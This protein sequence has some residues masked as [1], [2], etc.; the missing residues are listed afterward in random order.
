MKGEIFDLIG[1]LGLFLGIV[2]VLFF[3]ASLMRG[4]FDLGIIC[5]LSGLIFI[6]MGS[7]IL[8]ILDKREKEKVK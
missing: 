5:L 7:L 3:P 6:L 1:G 8:S 2:L 4:D